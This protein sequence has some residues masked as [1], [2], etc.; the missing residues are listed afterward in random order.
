M[1]AEGEGM[2]RT[3]RISFRDHD[4]PALKKGPIKDYDR[5]PYDPYEVGRA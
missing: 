1:A 3:V 4:A 5:Y 2:I